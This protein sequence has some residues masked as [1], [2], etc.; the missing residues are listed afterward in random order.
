MNFQSLA[1]LTVCAAML[2]STLIVGAILIPDP[3]LNTR[4]LNRRVLATLAYLP[5]FAVFV[6]WVFGLSVVDDGTRSVVLLG[7][8]LA[9]VF[10]GAAL[11]MLWRWLPQPAGDA[12]AK[13]AGPS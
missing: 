7:V 5:V 1:I 2:S 6:Y 11:L 10:S 9:A 13:I 3:I 12:P 8:F 4:N